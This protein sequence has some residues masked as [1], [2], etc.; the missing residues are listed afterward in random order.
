MISPRSIGRLPK[1]CPSRRYSCVVV[2]ITGPLL[3]G[4][5]RV[6]R[7][8]LAEMTSSARGAVPTGSF[9]G[10]MTRRA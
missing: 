8:L 7:P 10:L 5:D 3:E 6:G 9:T 1:H 4:P 2:F